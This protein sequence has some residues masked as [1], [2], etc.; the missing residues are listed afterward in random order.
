MMI[1]AGDLRRASGEEPFDRVPSIFTPPAVSSRLIA[2]LWMP[3][4]NIF[5]RAPRLTTLRDLL[6]ESLR[7]HLVCSSFTLI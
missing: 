3:D 4:A 5:A 2:Q 7:N 6:L 1:T